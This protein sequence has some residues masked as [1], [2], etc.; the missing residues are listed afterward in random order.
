MRRRAA[1]PLSGAVALALA[2][3]A[4]ACLVAP[5]P[6][7]AQV[8][9]GYDNPETAQ[10]YTY[11]LGLVQRQ[12][13]EEAATVLGRVLADPQPFSKRDGALFWYGETLSRLKRYGDA[14]AAFFF[15][16]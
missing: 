2:L 6:V 9:T 15:V 13:Y 5:L 8:S 7:A 14:I 10:Q 3:V 16:A 12:L 4:P 11:A 1:T